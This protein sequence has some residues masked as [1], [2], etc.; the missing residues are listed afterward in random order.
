MGDKLTCIHQ[1]SVNMKIKTNIIQMNITNST[2]I[3]NTL[4][5]VIMGKTFQCINWLSK[6]CKCF[7]YSSIPLGKKLFTCLQ[8]GNQIILINVLNKLAKV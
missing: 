2:Y 8:Q 5:E 1:I 7:T 4:S 3:G 6:L